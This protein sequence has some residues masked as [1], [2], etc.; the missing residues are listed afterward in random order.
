MKKLFVRYELANQLKEKGFN[1]P[2]LKKSEHKKECGHKINGNCPLHNLHCGY[3]DCEIDKT[4]ESIGLPLYQQVVDWFR[5]K[6]NIFLMPA[7]LTLDEKNPIYKCG[8]FSLITGDELATAEFDEDYYK[9]II[10]AIEE[11]LKL[12]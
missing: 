3:P 12:I 7:I 11:A 6:H 2:C 10:K 8:I 5:E 1:E 9:S 4:I